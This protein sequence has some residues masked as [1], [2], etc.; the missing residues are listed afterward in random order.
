MPHKA[1]KRPSLRAGAC[2]PA[3]SATVAA[4]RAC[5]CGGGRSAKGERG[6]SWCFP[7]WRGL[8]LTGA[9]AGSP[10]GPPEAHLCGHC[11]VTSC[12][13]PLQQ[14]CPTDGTPPCPCRPTRSPSVRPPSAWG[15]A[16]WRSPS[17]QHRKRGETRVRAC[18]LLEPARQRRRRRGVVVHAWA[19]LPGAAAGAGAGAAAAASSALACGLTRCRRHLPHL[20]LCRAR[21]RAARGDRGHLQGAQDPAHPAL[22]HRRV[23]GFECGAGAG[24]LGCQASWRQ[25]Q[26]LAPAPCSRQ[27]TTH[28]AQTARVHQDPLHAPVPLCQHLLPPGCSPCRRRPHQGHVAAAGLLICVNR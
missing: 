21:P 19:P 16:S 7:Y 24:L 18:A 9:S 8:P 28:R 26:C 6:S 15:P 27:H 13:L 25:R 23:L 2:E 20:L 14:I 11:T 10:A 5:V 22:Q 3:V 17:T 1:R 4:L 12:C